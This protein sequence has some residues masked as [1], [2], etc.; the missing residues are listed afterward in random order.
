MATENVV[1]VTEKLNFKFYVILTNLTLDRL[2]GL[3]AVVLDST[4]LVYAME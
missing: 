3:V 1:S 2:L 4:D